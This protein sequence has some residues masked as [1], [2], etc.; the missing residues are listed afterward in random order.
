MRL[1]DGRTTSPE[2]VIEMVRFG[3]L[4]DIQ[5]QLSVGLVPVGCVVRKGR[6]LHCDLSDFLISR[7][8]PHDILEAELVVVQQQLQLLSTRDEDRDR[9][10]E[11][12]RDHVRASRVG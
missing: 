2:V 6:A 4:V 11:V 3:E 12:D 1:T 7:L 8:I 9:R 5:D 10:L